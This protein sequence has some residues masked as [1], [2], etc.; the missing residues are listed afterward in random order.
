V[1]SEGVG[2]PSDLRGEADCGLSDI[3]VGV[4]S[5]SRPSYQKAVGTKSALRLNP[6]P[7]NR[8]VDPKVYGMFRLVN[9]EPVDRIP[10]PFLLIMTNGECVWNA[11]RAHS[12]LAGKGGCW[13]RERDVCIQKG[14]DQNPVSLVVGHSPSLLHFTPYTR[15]FFLMGESEVG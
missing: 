2:A 1:G 3:V 13:A 4:G 12:G 10:F 15:C 5:L 7:P 9:L 11:G 8:P 14:P 6:P